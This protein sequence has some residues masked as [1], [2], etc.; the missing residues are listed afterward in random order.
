MPEKCTQIIIRGQVQGV[1]FRKFTKGKARELGISGFVRN[2][3]DGSVYI[4]ACGENSHLEKFIL[5]CHYGPEHARVEKVEVKEIESKSFSS[6]SIT[7]F[8]K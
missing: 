7:Y 4:E 6:F 3:Y 8:Q 5:W 1:F 2:E